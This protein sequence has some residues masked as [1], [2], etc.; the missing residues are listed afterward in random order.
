MKAY[1][2]AQQGCDE[3]YEANEIQEY[4]EWYE[5]NEIAI[6]EEL[7]RRRAKAQDKSRKEEVKERKEADKKEALERKLYEKLRVKYEIE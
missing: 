3:W 4:D 6:L 1:E 2:L 5:A 7:E